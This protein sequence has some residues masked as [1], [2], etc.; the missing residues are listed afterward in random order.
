MKTFELEEILKAPIQTLESVL[1]E[2]KRIVVMDRAID[3]AGTYLV[4]ISL[5]LF[6]DLVRTF[7]QFIHIY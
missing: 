4:D 7:K 2:N 1:K 3:S 6:E 5:C